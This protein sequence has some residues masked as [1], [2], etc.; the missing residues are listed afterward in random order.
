MEEDTDMPTTLEGA[1]STLGLA[2]LMEVFL[3]E[4][5]DFDSLVGHSSQR[6]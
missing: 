5:I 2:E 1:L 6:I 3:K 4:Q